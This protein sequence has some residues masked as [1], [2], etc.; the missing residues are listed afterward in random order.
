MNQR[1]GRDEPKKIYAKP[2]DTDK[3]EV[4][5]GRKEEGG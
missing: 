2:M 5:A 3:Y 4:M 1:R